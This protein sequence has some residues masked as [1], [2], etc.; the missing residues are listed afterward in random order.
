MFSSG[1]SSIEEG[2]F[3]V[4]GTLNGLRLR[5]ISALRTNHIDGFTHTTF[6]VLESRVIEL[7]EI[8]RLDAPVLFI[9][10]LQHIEGRVVH[11]TADLHHGYEI[12]IETRAPEPAD[13]D[14]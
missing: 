14:P 3:P 10:N 12:T 5:K 6:R 13:P 4:N 7:E 9:L 1:N 2:R 8:L 11:Y